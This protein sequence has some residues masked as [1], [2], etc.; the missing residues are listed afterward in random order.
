MNLSTLKPAEGSKHSTNFRVGVDM[1]QE[2]AR[3]QVRAIRV[4]RHVQVHLDQDLKAVR[5]LYIEESQKEDLH[6]LITKIS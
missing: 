6:V 3:L 4:R 1:V 2:M 5:C